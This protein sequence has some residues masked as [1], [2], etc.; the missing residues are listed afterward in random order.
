MAINH[1]QMR[2]LLSLGAAA[3]TL[4]ITTSRPDRAVRAALGRIEATTG[5]TLLVASGEGRGRRYL[6]I[7]RDLMAALGGHVATCPAAK[8]KRAVP[9]RPASSRTP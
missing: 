6:V 9:N 1:G 3:G 4:G 5:M 8:K 2:G 7:E